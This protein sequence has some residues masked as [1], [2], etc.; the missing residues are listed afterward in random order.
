M[1]AAG[2]QLEWLPVP[3][4]NPLSRKSTL[5]FSEFVDDPVIGHR[6]FKRQ[7]HTVVCRWIEGGRK[8]V[9]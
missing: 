7:L 8:V 5:G 2:F 9:F 6:L 4:L 3:R 1:Q